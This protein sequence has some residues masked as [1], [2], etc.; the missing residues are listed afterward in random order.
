MRYQLGVI[1]YPAG[2]YGVGG[3]VPRV[4]AHDCTD[5]EVLDCARHCGPGLAKKMAARKG[6]T[7]NTRTWPTE[8]AARAEALAL[9]FKC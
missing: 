6:T 4:L 8:E 2:V 9:G 7:F 1:E 3:A 5:P